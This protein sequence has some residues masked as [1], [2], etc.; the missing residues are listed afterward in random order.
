VTAARV[1]RIDV[2]PP[3]EEV[4]S[5]SG[6]RLPVRVWRPPAAAAPRGVV[7]AL[8]GMVTHSGWFALLGERL[9]AQ[10][11]ALMAPDRR[12]NGWAQALRDPGE[13]ELL[14]SDVEAVVARARQ[15]SVDVTL[16]SWCG[17]AN[18]AVLAAA[19]VPIR[20]LVLASPGLVP[21]PAMSARLRASEPI[22]PDGAF[23]PVHFDPASDFTDDEATRRAIR[24]D[25]LT[26]RRIP[27]ALREAWRQLN[28]RARQALATL[29]IPTRC[30]LTRVD[31]MLD[32]P[33]TLEL[34]AAADIPVH[35][36]E[37]GHGFVVEPAGAHAVA[38]LLGAP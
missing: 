32:I 18:F 3:D 20:R 26:L 25:A 34:L 4:A 23:L 7:V 37:G 13:I 28:P 19:R 6:E 1:A 15:L 38:N 16:L 9:A 30:V 2:A 12:G 8:H 36:A 5:A 33:A 27:L 29:P 35:W 17:S 11:L 24:G 14:L 31:R 21:L 22:D 10:G